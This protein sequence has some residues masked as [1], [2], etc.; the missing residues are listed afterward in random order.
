VPYVSRV[1]GDHAR[2]D[3]ECMRC[4]SW[5]ERLSA[6]ACSDRVDVEVV[7]FHLTSLSHAAQCGLESEG[8]GVRWGLYG[9]GIGS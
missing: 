4:M 2:D 7:G 5:S 1:V 9:R 8:R 6:V 3:T